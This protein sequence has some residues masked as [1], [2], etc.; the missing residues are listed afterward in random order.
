MSSNAGGGGPAELGEDEVGREAGREAACLDTRSCW[1][2]SAML[3]SMLS[4]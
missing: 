3:L 2:G 4:E 1:T